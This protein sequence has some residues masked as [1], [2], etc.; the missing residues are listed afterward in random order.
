MPERL[1]YTAILKR[2]KNRGNRIRQEKP[3]SERRPTM[4]SGV[5]EISASRF[6]QLHSVCLQQR[7]DGPQ[8][9]QH[10]FRYAVVHLHYRQ[11]FT[12]LR[13]CVHGRCAKL[14]MFTPRTCPRVVPIWPIT[15]RHVQV[16]AHQQAALEGGF[17]VDSV[18]L[19]QPRL[20]LRE[21]RSR[22]RGSF[23]RPCSTIGEHACR[24]ARDA[25][26]FVFVH[27]NAALLRHGC[28][29][30]PFTCSEPCSSRQ[31]PRCA[32]VPS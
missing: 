17:D 12:G 25:L 8:R 10:R 20:L 19:Q 24:A 9:L 4:Q 29:I 11:R 6:R 1:K 3:V 18:E 13:R 16:S 15:P 5:D 30:D 14:A 7:L 2:R 28:R 31:W 26:L 21:S 32:P 23:R 22:W 27:T